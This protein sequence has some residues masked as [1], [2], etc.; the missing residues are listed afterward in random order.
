MSESAEI[1]TNFKEYVHALSEDNLCAIAMGA[2]YIYIN[3]S[4]DF[5][6][7]APNYSDNNAIREYWGDGWEALYSSFFR[8]DLDMPPADAEL[9]EKYCEEGLNEAEAKALAERERVAILE[10]VDMVMIADTL[11]VLDDRISS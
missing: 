6:L 7:L 5:E 11:H 1:L 3:A 8:S 10:T 4:K 9:C 2:Q